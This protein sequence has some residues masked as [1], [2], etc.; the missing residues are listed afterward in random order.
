VADQFQIIPLK[1]AIDGND[2]PPAQIQHA[3][4][5]LARQTNAAV[6][7]LAAG[8]I[9]G[10]TTVENGGT[11]QTNLPAN[12]LLLGSG[13]AP[14]ASVAPGTAGQVLTSTGPSSAPAFSTP[15]AVGL[16]LPN[17]VDGLNTLGVEPRHQVVATRGQYPKS[18][19]SNGTDTGQNTR[20]PVVFPQGASGIQ[21]DFTNTSSTAES[22]SPG[23]A[24]QVTVA[25]EFP[26]GTIYPAFQ[27]GNRIITVNN[28]LSS[29]L[30]DP[31]EIDIPAGATAFIRSF[32]S[33][34]TAGMKWPVGLSMIVGQ[35]GCA[36]GTTQVDETLN[37]AFSYPS[38]FIFGFTPTAVIAKSAKKVSAVAVIGDSIAA[39][40]GD[41]PNDMGFIVRSLLAAGIPYVNL[42]MPGETAAQFQGSGR[43]NRI[44]YT[45]FA[46]NAICEYGT[47]DIELSS[48]L[49][50]LQTNII[51][52]WTAAWER[53]AKV[54]Q[55]TILPRVTTTDNLTTSGGQTP[56]AGF[57][58]GGI[59]SQFNAWVRA[60]AP[61]IPSL[62]GPLVAVAIGTS[63][64][65]LAGNPSHPLRGFFEAA[66]LVETAQDSGL[67]ITTGR[68]VSDAAMVSGTK[69]ITSA[70]ANFTTADNGFNLTIAGAAAGGAAL[71]AGAMTF[72]NATTVTVLIAAST[73]VVGAVANIRT[74]VMSVDGTHPSP[75]GHQTLEPAIQTNQLTF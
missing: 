33:V 18:G 46:G 61:V 55:T 45:R 17:Q 71:N 73:T 6:N 5:D 9:G 21:F 59:R 72:V 38:D 24:Y 60:G 50:T 3:V 69:T 70:T 10:T 8:G 65:L 29:G 15:A 4:N 43:L 14:V 56:I 7:Q 57:E 39:G 44:A 16:V 68:N 27:S 41:A 49:A 11:G 13:A 51:S 35:D 19:L 75:L 22:L 23:N 34:V 47:N 54:W 42:A 1:M 52:I 25:I 40:Q 63:G 30:F 12:E 2:T 26:A 32:V 36:T 64:A 31:V 74:F 37:G 20:I 67:W 66:N 58:T 62:D 48:S 53:G 28:T